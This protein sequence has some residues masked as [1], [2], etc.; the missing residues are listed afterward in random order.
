MVEPLCLETKEGFMEYWFDIA[1]SNVPY[2]DRIPACRAAARKLIGSVAA[3]AP[4]ILEVGARAHGDIVHKNFVAFAT[5]YKD[6]AKRLTLKEKL[7][8]GGLTGLY[9]LDGNDIITLRRNEWI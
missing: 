4:Y 9:P 6:T 2:S 7:E 5:F 8:I 3:D 1:P